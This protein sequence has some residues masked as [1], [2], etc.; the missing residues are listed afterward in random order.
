[1]ELQKN[2]FSILEKEFLHYH[3]WKL[4]PSHMVNYFVNVSFVFAKTKTNIF[5]IHRWTSSLLS[6]IDV[7]F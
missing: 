6:K 7:E 3:Y 4:L 5:W 2:T 1:M